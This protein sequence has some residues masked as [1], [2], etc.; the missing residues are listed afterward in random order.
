M[1]LSWGDRP[2]RPKSGVAIQN[3]DGRTQYHCAMHVTAYESAGAILSG[4]NINNWTYPAGATNIIKLIKKM[5][6]QDAVEGPLEE[7]LNDMVEAVKVVNAGRLSS[8]GGSRAV[9]VDEVH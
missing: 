2:D 3:G 6:I 8:T 9:R 7:L 1:H 5:V 4:N